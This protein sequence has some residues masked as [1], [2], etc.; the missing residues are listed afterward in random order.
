MFYNNYTTYFYCLGPL[1]LIVDSEKRS[2][3]KGV[4]VHAKGQVT[5]DIE[6]FSCSLNIAS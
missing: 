2:F 1:S 3:T 4:S 6:E 5:Y